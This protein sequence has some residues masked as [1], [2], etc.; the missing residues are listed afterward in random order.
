MQFDSFEKVFS[1]MFQHICC[2]FYHFKDT[3]GQRDLRPK[4]WVFFNFVSDIP[5]IFPSDIPVVEIK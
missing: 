4:L 5:K 2:N 3:R 1:R